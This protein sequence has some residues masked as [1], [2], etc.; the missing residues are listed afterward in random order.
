[1]KIE[2][3]INVRAL[4]AE[5]HGPGGQLWRWMEKRA[6][7]AVAG[8]KRQAG[9]KTGALRKSIYHR[10]YRTVAGQSVW[11]GSYKKYAYMH[12][13]GTRPHI[14]TPKAPNTVLVFSRRSRVI[15]TEMVRHP[16]TKPNRYLS[17]QLRHFLR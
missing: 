9:K 16:G 6:K 15:V 12:H 5:L 17:N 13:E 8:A 10:H 3:Y 11:I 4:D 2:L 14:I 1:M 7:R